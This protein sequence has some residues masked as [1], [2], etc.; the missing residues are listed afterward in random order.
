VPNLATVFPLQKLFSRL[1]IKEVKVSK[2]ASIADNNMHRQSVSGM[3]AAGL[4]SMGTQDEALHTLGRI[5]HKVADD[6]HCQFRA[7]A[8][9]V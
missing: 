7:I 9:Q 2:I 1:S 8:H 4:C 6:G 3:D 5:I